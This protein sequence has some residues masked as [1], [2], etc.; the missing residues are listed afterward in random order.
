M[1]TLGMSP[2]DDDDDVM[3]FF[4]INY[5]VMVPL[6]GAVVGRYLLCPGH[7]SVPAT[8]RRLAQRVPDSAAHEDAEGL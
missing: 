2:D 5:S 7:L 1:K 6:T 4:L 3:G 8:G